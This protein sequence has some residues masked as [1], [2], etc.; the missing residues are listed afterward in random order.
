MKN[1]LFTRVRRPTAKIAEEWAHGANLA[2]PSAAGLTPWLAGNVLPVREG[3]YER[4]MWQYSER[5]YWNTKQWLHE[6]GGSPIAKTWDTTCWRGLSEP[7][8]AN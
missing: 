6:P 8:D 1:S 2:F 5:Q 7:A 4:L 3:W